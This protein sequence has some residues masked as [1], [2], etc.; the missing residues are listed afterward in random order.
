MP[1]RQYLKTSKLSMGENQNLILVVEDGV[2]SD[3]FLKHEDNKEAVTRLIEDYIERK[4]EL[5]IRVLQY[6]T[7]FEENY[8]D[9]TKIINIEIEEEE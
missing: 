8:I 7:G 5:D 6:N 9:L 1:M 4:V 3:Y 2:A